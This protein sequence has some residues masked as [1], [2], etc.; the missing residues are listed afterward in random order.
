MSRSFDLDWDPR[1]H[2]DG[3]WVA[4]VT[5]RNGN[6]ELWLIDR[7]AREERRLTENDWEWDKHP[8]WSPDGNSLAFFSNRVSGQRQIWILDPWSPKQAGVNPRNISNNTYDD[9]DPVWL[10]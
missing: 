5:T 4:F 2:P 1:L 7:E 9:F 10:K 3:W 8:T 6:D